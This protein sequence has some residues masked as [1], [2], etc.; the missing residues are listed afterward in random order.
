ML[1]EKL[2]NFFVRL[3]VQIGLTTIP[4][5]VCP[6]SLFKDH[7]P[8][9]PQQMFFLNAHQYRWCKFHVSI[10]F[11]CSLGQVLCAGALTRDCQCFLQSLINKSLKLNDGL[12]CFLVSRQISKKRRN[13]DN[14]WNGRA[15]C[16]QYIHIL[17]LPNWK[18]V[19]QY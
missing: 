8:P 3:N 16:F 6:H 12:F 15:Q 5:P 18:R 10:F 1:F 2:S 19:N 9:P 13:Q 11:G 14:F 4:R 7:P 17:N